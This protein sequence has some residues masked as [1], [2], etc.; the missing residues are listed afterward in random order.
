M[1]MK[2][3]PLFLVDIN[4]SRIR[5]LLVPMSYLKEQNVTR[6]FNR[7]F[8]FFKDFIQGNFCHHTFHKHKKAS[9][10]LAFKKSL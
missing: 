9:L 5:K 1:V 2:L 6:H 3:Y 7:N 10:T 8:L 4:Q